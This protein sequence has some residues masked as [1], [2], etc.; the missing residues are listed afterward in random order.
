MGSELNYS[1]NVK[2]TLLY[3]SFD[4]VASWWNFKEVISP[5]T[6]LYLITEGEGWVYH[7]NQEFHLTPGTLFLI[8]K[9]TFH[10]YKCKE[11]MGHYY[12]CFLD[13]MTGGADM[14]DLLRFNFLVQARTEDYL[15]FKQLNALNPNRRIL[16]PDPAS[17]D[18]KEN[19][20][21]FLHRNLEQKISESIETQGIMLQ[22]ISRFINDDHTQHE[23]SRNQR[24]HLN[25][26][27]YFIDQNLDKKITLED[28]ANQVCLSADYF[29]KTF[30]EIMGI[31]PM[32]YVSRKRIERAQMLLITTNLSISQIAE[33]V[34][35]YNNSYFS[36]L[37]K[38]FTLS[39]P[40]SYKKLN[41]Q[42]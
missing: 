41:F 35:I 37:F 30:K 21:S 40:E 3:N 12:V 2:L 31:R 36:T 22:L 14:Y 6:R 20:H 10:S 7:N 17:Y 1:I 4:V 18:N 5:F 24:K 38:K 9:F 34:G 39:T 11:S 15:L 29:S 19:L 23:T 16:N 28:L 26:V 32:E 33:K 13:E 27:T 42:I 25:K 8:P